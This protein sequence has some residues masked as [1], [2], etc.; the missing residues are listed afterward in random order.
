MT[1]T[2]IEPQAPT[3][4]APVRSSVELDARRLKLIV[5]PALFAFIVLSSYGF[6]L[7]YNL[8][9]DVSLLTREISA[10]NRSVAT[11]MDSMASDLGTI[12][13]YMEALPPIAA[14]MAAINIRI[15]GID[16]KMQPIATSM[17][18]MNH[19]TSAMAAYTGHMQQDMRG[20]NRS[21]AGPMNMMPWNFFSQR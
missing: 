6:Y 12:T 9:Q 13:A 3:A 7:I 4:L 18:N 19:S 17:E 15:D 2:T 10:M 14:N 1:E 21:V 20:L 11:N 16:D 8:S 5:Y